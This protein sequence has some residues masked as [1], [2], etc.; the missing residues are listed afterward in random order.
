M[1]IRKLRLSVILSFIAIVALIT[2]S[3]SADAQKKRHPKQPEPA[4]DRALD[5]ETVKRTVK[6]WIML[7]APCHNLQATGTDNGPALLGAEAEKKFNNSKQLLSVFTHPEAH[8]LS[9]AIPALRKLTPIQ[10]EEMAIWF[11]RLKAPEDI[12]YEVNS[13]KPPP[14]LFVQNCAGCHGPDG[15]GGIGPNLTNVINRR[16]REEIIKLIEEP[17][18]AGV[19][20]NIMPP[21]PEL[22]IEERTLIT[23]WLIMLN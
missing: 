21:F 20:S 13:L 22:S 6:T 15:M 8:G 14:Y 12:A 16:K 4:L 23:E 17:K 19:T 11:A 3:S 5:E 1:G 2:F 18:S 7:C 9:E 10:R